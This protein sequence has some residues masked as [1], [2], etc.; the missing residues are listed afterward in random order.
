MKKRRNPV[1]DFAVYLLV[2]LIVGLLYRV[3]LRHR[4]IVLENLRQAFGDRYTEARRDAII[5][6]V[7]VHFATMLMEILHI[8]RKLHPET[9]RHRITLRG[10]E[11]VVD[12]LLKG[13]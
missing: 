7:Y 11:P 9:W 12:R 3:D 5:R 6:G 1:L 13:G 10:H 4:A 2:R 8:P